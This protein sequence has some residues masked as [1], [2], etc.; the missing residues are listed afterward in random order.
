LFVIKIT[1]RYPKRNHW[2]GPTCPVAKRVYAQV[3]NTKDDAQKCVDDLKLVYE[4][5]SSQ[6]LPL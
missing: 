4:K 3:F 5:L 6:I 2:V 1:N